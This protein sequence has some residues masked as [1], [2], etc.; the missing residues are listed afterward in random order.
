MTNKLKVTMTDREIN[1]LRAA[2][3]M[4]HA[5][6][7]QSFMAVGDITDCFS[8]PAHDVDTALDAYAGEYIS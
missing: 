8:I 5:I 1:L 3:A 7:D 6:R 2:R 4:Y